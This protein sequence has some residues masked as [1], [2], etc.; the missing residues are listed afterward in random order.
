MKTHETSGLFLLLALTAAAVT[1]D[2]AHI[3]VPSP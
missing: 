2:Q 1:L 3:T